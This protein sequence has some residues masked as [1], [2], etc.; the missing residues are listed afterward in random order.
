MTTPQ[1]P[2]PEKYARLQEEIKAPYRG[3]RQFIYLAFGAS[4]LI[5][6]VVFL[7]QLAAG[8][9]VDTALPNFALQLGILALM[10]W[11]FRF[12]QRA[13]RKSP[14]KKPKRDL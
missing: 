7:S 8:R 5:G 3:L 11:L 9:E 4:G 12:E 6:A 14:A 10:V 2:N 1:P 13:S